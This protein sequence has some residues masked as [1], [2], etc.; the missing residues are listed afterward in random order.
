M[1]MEI[2]ELFPFPA[3][4]R[5]KNKSCDMVQMMEREKCSLRRCSGCV[6]A[7]CFSNQ[8]MGSILLEQ[9]SGNCCAERIGRI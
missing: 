9:G 3:L 8:D 6:K 1:D 7:G 4:Q 2:H 5:D